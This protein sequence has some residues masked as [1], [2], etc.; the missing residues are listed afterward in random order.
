MAINNEFN[1]E[2]TII[3][4]VQ[5]AVKPSLRYPDSYCSYTNGAE[6]HYGPEARPHRPAA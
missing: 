4:P 1:R 6:R 5:I 3:K 2:C